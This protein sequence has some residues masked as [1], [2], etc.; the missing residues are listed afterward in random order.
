MIYKHIKTEIDAHSVA[1]KVIL[2]K[3]GPKA[4]WEQGGIIFGSKAEPLETL[5][6][7]CL[8]S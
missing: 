7:N 2:V 8:V 3:L 1:A 5:N 4:C 6:A